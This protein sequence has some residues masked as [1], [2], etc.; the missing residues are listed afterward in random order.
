[1]ELQ[2]WKEKNAC[3]KRYAHFD[4]KLTLKEVWDYI[5]NPFNIEHHGFYP[6]IHYKKEN[7]KSK[8]ENGK[9]IT[10]SKIRHLCYCSHIDRYIFSYYAYLINQIYNK[11]L[12]EHNLNMCSIAYRDNLHKNNIHF[13]KIAFDKIKETDECFIIIGDFTNFFDSLDHIYLKKQLCKLLNTDKLPPDYYS[14]FKNVTKYSMWELIDILHLNHLNDIVKD[15]VTLNLK[16]KVLTKAEFKKYKSKYIIKNKENFGIPQGSPISA[17]L[18][19]IYMIIL[20][21]QINQLINQFLGL[22]MRYSDD[23]IIILPKI[24][25]DVFKHLLIKIRDYIH[26]IPNLNL[27]PEKTQIYYYINKEL[28][29]CNSYFLENIKDGKHEIDYLGFNFNGQ[30]VTIRDKTISKY[31]YKLYRKTKTIIRKKGV[32]SH[33]NKISC[34]N[35]Y[36]KYSIKGAYLRNSNGHIRGNFITY[37]QRAQRIYGVQEP[38]NR[39]TKNHMSKIRRKLNKAY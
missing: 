36:Q 32:T 18:A 19:N 38:I 13:S 10:K 33:G 9:V 28:I 22:Y 15:R 11:Y 35:L 30:E 16:N 5:S 29:N 12:I 27:Q 4:N 34:Q 23:F 3:S 2:E 24:S 8:K 25:E 14:V 6:F 26:S 1:M 21:E 7:Y 39:K 31:Y 37:V 17:V 20:D